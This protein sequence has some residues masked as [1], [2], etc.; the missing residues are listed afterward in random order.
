VGQ[1]TFSAD[2]LEEQGLARQDLPNGLKEI[3][4]RVLAMDSASSHPRR[5][6]RV[7]A[8]MAVEELEAEL[9]RLIEEQVA[10]RIQQMTATLQQELETAHVR[11]L[12]AF[13]QDVNVKLV[14]RISALETNITSQGEAMSE[15]RGH[16]RRT[17]DNLVRLITGVERLTR[18]LPAGKL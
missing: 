5:Q 15:L 12:E 13:V 9:P 10:L 7:S 4:D 18:D 17:E 11:A 16:L 14:K 3:V 1:I 6:R 2:S 8:G